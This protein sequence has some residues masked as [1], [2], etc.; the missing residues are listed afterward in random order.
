MTGP[1]AF[2][3]VL[4]HRYTDPRPHD[5]SGHGNVGFGT[6]THTQGRGGTLAALAFDGAHDRIYVPPSPTLARPGGFRTDMVVNVEALG[7]RRTLIEGYLS[8]ALYV[9]ADGAVGGS[10]Y[11]YK[12]WHSLQ[13]ASG[14][15]RVG[16]WITVTLMYSSDGI[17]TLLLDGEQAAVDYRRL[18]PCNAIAWPFGLS[19]GAWPD[20][21][22][23]VLKGRIEEVR[24]WRSLGI[25]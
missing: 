15:V 2:E 16:D 8:F 14:A 17:M 22:Q 7:Y 23:R 12:D 21:D 18:G 3:L 20:A 11:R 13:T 9:E 5:L 25:A 4:H 6:A 10:V 1:D 24:L 19:I